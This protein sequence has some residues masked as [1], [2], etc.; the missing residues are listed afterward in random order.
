MRH[1]TVG[2]LRGAALDAFSQEPLGA[3]NPLLQLPQ[4][5]YPDATYGRAYGRRDQCDQ[6]VDEMA[7][8][9]C[10]AVLQPGRNWRYRVV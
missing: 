9:D 8:A 10:L 6:T 7:L 5:S 3:E 1:L 2:K 4:Q